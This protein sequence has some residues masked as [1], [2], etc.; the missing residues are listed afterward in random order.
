MILYTLYDATDEGSCIVAEAFGFPNHFWLVN[1]DRI[2]NRVYCIWCLWNNLIQPFN[3]LSSHL[4]VQIDDFIVAPIGK[5]LAV[6]LRVVSKHLRCV[7][8]ACVVHCV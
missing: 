3:V 6:P 5:S 1:S 7:R 8:A 4:L 2:I